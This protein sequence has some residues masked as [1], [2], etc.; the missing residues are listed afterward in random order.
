MIPPPRPTSSTVVLIITLM[1]VITLPASSESET[2]STAEEGGGD[3]GSGRL[4]TWTCAMDSCSQYLG[5]ANTTCSSMSLL[6]LITLPSQAEGDEPAARHLPDASQMWKLRRVGQLLDS[7]YQFGLNR[8][9]DL[10]IL[11]RFREIYLSAIGLFGSDPGRACLATQRSERLGHCQSG[12]VDER[13]SIEEPAPSRRISYRRRDRGSPAEVPISGRQLL[14]EPLRIIAAD[15]RRRDL[16]GHHSHQK[17]VVLAVQKQHT[18]AETAA[19]A[20]AVAL[21]ALLCTL[22]AGLLLW[23]I[24]K[25]NKPI[26]L[27]LLQTAERQLCPS[28]GPRRYSRDELAAATCGF[29]EEIGRGGF[30]PVYRGYLKDLGRPVAV[31]VLSQ[32]SSSSS[33]QQ[34][35]KEFEAEVK[36]MTSLRH[37]NIIQLLGWSNGSGELLLVYELM[38]NGSLDKLLYDSHILLSWTK[39]YNIALGVGSAMLYLHTECEQCVV[40]GDIKPANVM[41]DASYTAKLGDFGL[42]RLMDHGADSRTTQI[43]AGTVGYID[44]EF[45]NDRRRG[46]ESDVY[47]FGVLLLEIACGRR[48]TSRQP[49]GG[50]HAE[51]PLL[52][53]VGRMY[54]RGSILGAADPRLCGDFEAWQMG[55][56]LT[57]GLWCA[58]R[59]R[60]RRPSMARAM[61][62]LRRQGDHVDELPVLAAMQDPDAA[63]SPLELEE[64]ACRDLSAADDSNRSAHDTAYHTSKGSTCLLASVEA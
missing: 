42:A 40:H 25:R 39:R 1:L 8:S 53:W 9:F 17:E 62:A 10:D 5:V 46:A 43:V 35:T 7:T 4:I 48:A 23:C 11:D 3:L 19:I 44:P 54:R 15:G 51:L 34:G 55:R 49:N 37:R 12:L 59:D 61:D 47:S 38:P 27:Q 50:A 13:L 58:H 22:A 57:V 56:V 36:I 20:A 21:F 64:R 63:R 33:A 32:G 52:N 24:C 29:V 28:S 26:Q 60:S 2:R 14:S 31:K 30:G 6:L 16:H 45:L 18:T 41:L